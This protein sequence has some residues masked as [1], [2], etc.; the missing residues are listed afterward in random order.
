MPNQ[1]K[2]LDMSP[3][4]S[5]DGDDKAVHVGGGFPTIHLDS[6]HLKTLGIKNAKVGDKYEIHAHGHVTSQSQHQDTDE[7][8]QAGEPRGHISMDLKKMAVS[9]G[10]LAAKDEAG[11]D[12][13][14]AKAVMD[15]ALKAP[16]KKR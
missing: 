16:A 8:G 11:G 13:Q 6:H 5:E 2:L 1:D 3:P 10:K 4:P 12:V 9:A 7:D 14:S 15:Q